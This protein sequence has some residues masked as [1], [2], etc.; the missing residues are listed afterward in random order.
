MSI[1]QSS[2]SFHHLSEL[3]PA[4]SFT[5]FRKAAIRTFIAGLLF[6]AAIGYTVTASAERTISPDASTSDALTSTTSSTIEP[7]D[8]AFMAASGEPGGYSLSEVMLL[9]L[10]CNPNWE[11]FAA[12]HAAAH[13]ELLKALA[14]PNPEIDVEGGS[15][16]G[17]ETDEDGRRPTRG[18]YSLSL[19]QPIELPGKRAAR[20]AEAEAG[21]AVA[22]AEGFEFSSTL[23]ADIVEAYFT[24]QYHAA[25]EKLWGA[26]LQGAEELLK[27]AE[28]RVSLGEAARLEIVNA[29]IERLKA[30]RQR[31]AENRRRLGARA[32]LNALT[33]GTLPRDFKLAESLPEQLG[34]RSI[35]TARKSA[36]ES[37]PRLYR[38]KAELEQKYSS[39]DRARTEWWPD[40]KIGVTTG[41]EFDAQSNAVT[42]GIQIPLWNRNQGGVAAANAAARK[43]YNDIIIAFNELNRDVEVV[44]QQYELAREQLLAYEDGLLAASREAFDLAWTQYR[45]GAAGYLDVLTARRLMQETLQGLIDARFEA[46]TVCARLDRAAGSVIQC[47]PARSSKAARRNQ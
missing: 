30:E 28:T 33:G 46:A 25:L 45:G 47:P 9:A 18:I 41:K 43:T 15:A 42:A 1:S 20:A 11:T 3:E 6:G 35:E 22:R 37:H 5:S 24:V 23:R 29:R 21:F 39:I 4:R 13:A 8:Q 17:R 2:R 14:F 27:L 36:F 12:N 31:N 32:A 10:K 38:L 19:A 26:Q 44:Y 40:I 16:R 7:S 34:M